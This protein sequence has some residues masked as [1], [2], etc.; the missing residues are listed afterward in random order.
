MEIQYRLTTNA[1]M[2]ADVENRQITGYGIV[3]NSD[4]LPLSVS[5]GANGSVR[6]VEQITQRS[7]ENADM[8]DVI[9]AYNHN[10]EKILGRT[11][12]NTLTLTTD[13][14]GVK[15]T[16]KAGN[17]TYANDLLESLQRGDVA[18]SSF[19]FTYD[20]NEGYEFEE[21]AD[22]TLIATPRK[23]TKVYEMGPV[24]SPAYPETTAQN[25]NGEL[26]K[27]VQ[28]HLEAQRA[29]PGPDVDEP[30]IDGPDEVEEVTEQ[31]KEAEQRTIYPA[32]YYALKA[33]I[34]KRV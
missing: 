17:Q 10:F 34:K 24:T 5:D 32:N 4:S 11:T 7:L 13:Q 2:T 14:R 9:S 28:R 1:D 23:I 30:Q 6:V 29:Q 33:K 25:R 19:V 18:G 16:V 26:Q 20:Y 27:A 12:S 31:P 8:S 22:G 21:R 15:Y 3:F